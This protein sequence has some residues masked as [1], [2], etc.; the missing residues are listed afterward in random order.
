M[1]FGTFHGRG[2][3]LIACDMEDV[4]LNTNWDDVTCPICLDFPH[5]GVL[6]L[7]SSYEKGCR[8]FVCD[9]DHLHSNCLDRFKNAYGVSPP[10]TSEVNSAANTQPMVSEDSC[11]PACPLCRGEVTGWVVA[12]KVRDYLNEKK[13]CC[14]EDQC[15]FAGTYLE[16]R[17]HAQLEH[18]HSRPSKIDPARQ[19]DWENFQQ[20]SEIIDVLSTIHSEVPR[21]VVLGD[22]V[23]EYGD[24]E[25]GDEF[26]DFP[27]DEGNWW[28][29]CI[30]YQVFD[31]LRNARNRRRSRVSDTRRGSRRSSYDTSNSDEGSVTSVDFAEYRIDET[32]DEFVSTSGPSRGSSSHRSSRRRRS[33]F[34]DN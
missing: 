19:L 20:S 16:L 9:T 28:T 12:D 27:G 24:D 34:Y 11:R 6:L 18:P 17:K 15:T 23:I 8:P 31:N 25:T 1:A 4:Q 3:R 21:G 10:S 5:N 29:S 2:H 13:R 7:C 30:L 33:R 22:Y 32:D 26:E 14:E